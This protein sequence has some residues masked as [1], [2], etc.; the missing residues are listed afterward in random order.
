MDDQP[1]SR[2]SDALFD[3]LSFRGD[4]EADAVIA[5]HVEHV[6]RRGDGDAAASPRALVAGIARNLNAPPEHRSGQVAAFLE[7]KPPLPSWAD[8][9]KLKR[10]ADFFA[11]HAVLIG[12][13]LFCASLPEA[14]AGA[15]GARVL[16]LTTRLVT[17]PVRRIYETAQMLF[18]SMVEG[19]LDPA[20]GA[21]Y[22]S[23]RRVR[24]MHAA[25]RHLVLTDPSV[26]RGAG[27]PF[28]SWDPERGAPINQEDLLGTL[29][30]FTQTV[31]EFLDRVGDVYGDDEADAYLHAWC[32]VGYLLGIEKNLLPLSLDD[33]REI[34]AAIRRRQYCPSDDGALLGQALVGAMRASVAWPVLRPLPAS[35]IYWAVGPE[36]AAI[37][38]I[39]GKGPFALAFRGLTAAVR[40]VGNEAVHHKFLRVAFRH[41][42]R[43]ALGAFVRAG[44]TGRPPFR[45]PDQLSTQ[46][47]APQGGWRV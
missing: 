47:D 10:S 38:G 25:V 40:T 43:G 11:E 27:L 31:F 3:E 8:P 35:L 39:R 34:T 45:I 20:T 42:G 36:V 15:R 13:G 17:D 19:G 28:P 4:A 14:Y 33:A 26:A 1:T 6:A 12:T 32:V 16:A 30:S 21:G 5:A 18:D 41:V 44:R 24:L 7:K 2:W 23:I 9:V 29:M 37:N 46:A 22:A